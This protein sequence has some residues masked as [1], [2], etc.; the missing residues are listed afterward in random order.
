MYMR[1]FSVETVVDEDNTALAVGSGDLEVFA[2]PMM[3]A[4]MENAA[5]ACIAEE[6]GEDNTSVGTALSISRVRATPTGMKV[7]ATAELVK[8]EGRKYDFKVTAEDER[9]LIGEGTHSRVSVNRERFLAKTYQ[10]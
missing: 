4:L 5:A 8:V 10:K 7:K 1:S 9:G 2:T 3:A 6:L